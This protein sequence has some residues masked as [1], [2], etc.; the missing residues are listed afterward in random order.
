MKTWDLKEMKLVIGS[1][2]IS[3]FE[4]GDILVVTR[5]EVSLTKQIGATG[6]GSRS[7]TNNRP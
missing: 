3:D 7:K 2:I 4:E 6:E 5:D 1:Y